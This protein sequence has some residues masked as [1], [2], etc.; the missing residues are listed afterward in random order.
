MGATEA[1]GYEWSKTMISNQLRRALK[2]SIPCPREHL[3]AE[4]QMGPLFRLGRVVARESTRELIHIPQTT[5]S[6]GGWLWL[7]LDDTR[8]VEI[9]FLDSTD[10][11]R[12]ALRYATDL[13]EE[14]VHAITAQC[15]PPERVSSTE[16]LCAK[17]PAPG[18]S[19]LGQPRTREHRDDI[20]VRLYKVSSDLYSDPSKPTLY[21]FG[22]VEVAVKPDGTIESAQL[23]S[24]E[25]A[26][27][28]ALDL[29]PSPYIRAASTDS[30]G[31]S[32]AETDWWQRTCAVVDFRHL[33]RDSD[34]KPLIER[35]LSRR[36][37]V[38]VL[39]QIEGPDMR[40][41]D[42]EIDTQQFRLLHDE[43]YGFELLT[44]DCGDIPLLRALAADLDFKR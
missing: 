37:N 5:L 22:Y 29:R 8:V 28:T 36:Y 7:D 15:E 39:G 33:R 25:A 38:H 1:F 24:P 18:W 44:E 9:E 14:M 30:E 10:E 41:F 4:Y 27:Q 6:L 11:E 21:R 43:P 32:D 12:S 16:D 2:A 34:F 40:I 31:A 26:I 20:T 35:L 17:I 23:L 3:F 42:F 13:G 19:L